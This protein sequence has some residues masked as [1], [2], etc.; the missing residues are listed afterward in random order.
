MDENHIINVILWSRIF[1]YSNLG[2]IE[3]LRGNVV[4]LVLYFS[5]YD[6]SMENEI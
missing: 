1:Y 3:F 6:Y 5:Y 4:V 2:D